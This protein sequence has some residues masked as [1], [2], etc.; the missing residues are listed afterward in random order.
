MHAYAR[1][2]HLER[3]LLSDQY[4]LGLTGSSGSQSRAPSHTPSHASRFSVLM[5][6]VL[7][8]LAAGESGR[9][10]DWANVAR[11]QIGGSNLGASYLL[12]KRTTLYWVAGY[13]KATG[14]NVSANGAIVP[15]QASVGSYGVNSG[16]SSQLVTVV[17]IRHKF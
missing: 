1:L 14:T 15:A 8:S 9:D 7:T 11:R 13:Q 10:S 12:S 5:S 2:I 4:G 17:G 6:S 3:R 16:T